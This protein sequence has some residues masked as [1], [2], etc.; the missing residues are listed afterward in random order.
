[1]NLGNLALEAGNPAE[2]E[3]QYREVL[4]L[5]PEYDGAHHNL[6]VALRR[7][8]KLQA[9]VGAIRKAQRLGVRRVQQDAKD[10]MQEQ[11]RVNP[12]LRLM[13]TVLFAVVALVILLV[14]LQGRGGA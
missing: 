4:K 12:R 3:A 14:F 7:Q 10:D 5:A 13:R 8:G 2:A 6:G 11:M 9:S 1:M